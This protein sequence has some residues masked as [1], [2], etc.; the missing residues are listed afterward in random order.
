MNELTPYQKV[1]QFHK[2]FNLFIGD[3]KKLPK[4]E[5]DL[6][7]RLIMEEFLELNEQI[8]YDH[9]KG[10]PS[11]NV[12]FID[13]IIDLIFVLYGMLVRLGVD[14]DYLF[15]VI[16]EANMNKE[17]GVMREDGKLLKPKNWT[18]PQEKIREYLIKKGVLL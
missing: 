13:A 18:P 4:K 8:I 3:G 7:I 17:G 16:W 15:D 5:F 11:D 6:G 9:S 1:K 10:L 12:E 14:G 2:K